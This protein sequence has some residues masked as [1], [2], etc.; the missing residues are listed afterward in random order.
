MSTLSLSPGAG[1]VQCVLCL[2]PT[3]KDALTDVHQAAYTFHMMTQP[4]KSFHIILTIINFGTFVAYRILAVI[5]A[6]FIL[7]R[8]NENEGCAS[9]RM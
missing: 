6:T 7:L 1:G 4:S 2:L 9:N 3:R 8:S 5:C